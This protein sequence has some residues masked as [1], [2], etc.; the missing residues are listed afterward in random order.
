MSNTLETLIAAIDEA[1]ERVSDAES[2]RDNFLEPILEV[3][4]AGY[5]EIFN[6]S[7]QEGTV[8]I[9]K[10]NDYYSKAKDYYNFPL[11]IFTS[12]DPL[13]AATEYAAAKKKAEADEDRKFKLETIHR[14][15]KE[16]SEANDV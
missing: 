13:A 2:D 12:D 6:C 11:A 10:E 7:I 15:Q 8:F 4:G 3:L 9:S 1:H 14:L 5:G 16:L